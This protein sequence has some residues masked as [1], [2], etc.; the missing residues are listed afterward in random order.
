MTIT[1]D[2]K[3][4][5]VFGGLLGQNKNNILE[6]FSAFEFYNTKSDSIEFDLS[7][8][9]ERKKMMEQLYPNYEIVGFFMTSQSTDCEPNSE[10]Q[11]VMDYFGVVSPICLVLSTNL[12][13]AEELPLACYEID[14]NNFKKI[15]YILEGGDSERIC[16]DTVTKSTDFQ[17]NESAVIQNMLTIKSAS[18]VLK[19]NLK[20][21]KGACSND[22]FKNDQYFIDLLEELINNYPQAKNEDTISYLT[23]QEKEIMVL[24]NICAGSILTSHLGRVEGYNKNSKYI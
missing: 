18:D 14:R 21:I 2:Q 17:N 10:L 16:L 20:T 23:Q 12:D 19:T 3:I 8:I 5:K 4:T 9:D 1:S 7:Y 11:K 13:K 6:I 15:D 24:N 22:K